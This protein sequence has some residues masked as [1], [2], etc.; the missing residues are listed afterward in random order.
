MELFEFYLIIYFQNA[1]PV[2]PWSSV[3]DATK[4]GPGCP[5]PTIKSEISEDCLRL[6]VYSNEVWL[7]VIKHLI[8]IQI[9]TIFSSIFAA[10]NC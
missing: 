10:S 4:E 6:N 3:Y 5:T 8:V 1:V 2:V 9:S 7:D